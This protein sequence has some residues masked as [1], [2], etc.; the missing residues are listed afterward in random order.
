MNVKI[1][2]LHIITSSSQ[3]SNS[4]VLNAESPK[5]LPDFAKQIIDIVA[6][7]K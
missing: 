4:S 5:I 6:E 2:Q 1:I 3:I 7:S